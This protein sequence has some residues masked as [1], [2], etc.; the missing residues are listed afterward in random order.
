MARAG[1]HL[2]AQGWGQMEIR[3][4]SARLDRFNPANNRGTERTDNGV[5]TQKEKRL[6]NL[7]ACVNG[8]SL[9][10]WRC[11]GEMLHKEE[12]GQ[13]NIDKAIAYA[14]RIGKAMAR[15]NK[16]ALCGVLRRPDLIP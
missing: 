12:H 13:P 5:Q 2:V 6:R 10:V 16:V 4:P 3:R 14:S 11:S 8:Q 1:Q 15:R 7:I 9:A